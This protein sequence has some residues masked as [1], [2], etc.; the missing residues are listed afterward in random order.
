MH[1]SSFATMYFPR[2]QGSTSV[3]MLANFWADRKYY[4]NIILY[5]EQFAASLRTFGHL[6]I[7]SSI[8]KQTIYRLISLQVDNC[9]Q[10]SYDI[11]EFYIFKL[12]LTYNLFQS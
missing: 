4:F 9:L 10:W 2:T 6:T 12:H 11:L 8:Q 1:R 3:F 7:Q 5:I